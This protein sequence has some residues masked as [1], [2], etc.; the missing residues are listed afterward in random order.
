MGAGDEV[1]MVANKT[2][3]IT[4]GRKSYD[5]LSKGGAHDWEQK[6]TKQEATWIESRAL[7]RK[8]S[9]KLIKETPLVWG[10][11]WEPALEMA[12]N[13]EPPPQIVFFMT[14]GSTGGDTVK[15]AKSLAA[16]ARTKNIIV[17]T[18]AMMEPKANAAMKELAKRTGGQ[19]TIIEQNGKAREV[20]LDD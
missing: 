2:A 4:S 10:T 18:V 15:I 7:E 6:G 20:P 9:L 1:K 12:F 3:T 17:N 16:K 5:W 19:F 14:D 13:M 8:K 11:L